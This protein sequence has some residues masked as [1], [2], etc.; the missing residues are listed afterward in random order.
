MQTGPLFRSFAGR[1]LLLVIVSGCKSTSVS[2]DDLDAGTGGPISVFPTDGG[3]DALADAA[4]RDGSLATAATGLPCDVA[5]VLGENCQQCHSSPPRFG[6]PV[7]LVSYADLSQ[8]AGGTSVAA[9]ALLRAKDPSKARMPPAPAQ[10]LSASEISTLERWEQAGMPRASD[11]CPIYPPKDSTGVECTPDRS[12][13][14][15]SKWTMPSTKSDEYVCYGVDFTEPQKRHVTAMAPRIG[16]SKIVH[17]LL[18]LDAPKAV[19]PVPFACPPTMASSWRLLYAWAPGGK[20][21]SLPPEAGFPLEGTKHYVMQVHYNNAQALAG[22]TDDSGID[23]CTTAALRPNDA[24]VIAFGT[25]KF[26]VPERGKLTRDCFVPVVGPLEGK[27]FFAAMPHMHNIGTSISTTLVPLTGAPVDMGTVPTWDFSNEYWLPLANVKAELGD[28]IRTVC[29]W[30]NKGNRPV[31]FGSST[32]DE[33]CYSF[34]M[35]Y[36]RISEAFQWG[37]PANAAQCP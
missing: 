5:K 12:V 36:P 22:E 6:A 4:A 17:H 2:G 3:V 37:L 8:N 34:T 15:Q 21:L 19:S 14:P 32:A 9:Q 27:T 16:N 29:S 31:S 11:A 33:M 1:A 25:D 13:R 20:A 23:L 26:T 28:R 35:Y 18:L 10:A 7:S 24:D 30:E